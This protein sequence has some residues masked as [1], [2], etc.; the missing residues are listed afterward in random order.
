MY[1]NFFSLKHPRVS[2]L[3]SNYFFTSKIVVQYAIYFY[4]YYTKQ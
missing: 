4:I 2:V 3:I 1:I